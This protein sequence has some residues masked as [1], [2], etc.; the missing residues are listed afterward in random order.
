MEDNITYPKYKYKN[1]M[2]QQL[3]KNNKKQQKIT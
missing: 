3:G 2:K 1:K